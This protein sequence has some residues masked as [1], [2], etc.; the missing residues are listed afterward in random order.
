VLFRSLSTGLFDGIIVTGGDIARALLDSVK[1]T[2]L[3]VIREVSPGIPLGIIPD[4][5]F[6]GMPIVTKAGGFGRQDAFVLAA[7]MLKKA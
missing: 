7:E 3:D 4:G 1:A 2:G 6:R 5:S